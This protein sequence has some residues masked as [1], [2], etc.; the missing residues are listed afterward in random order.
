MIHLEALRRANSETLQFDLSGEK[1]GR[2]SGLFQLCL[3]ARERLEEHGTAIEGLHD[4][5]IA[6]FGVSGH[7]AVLEIANIGDLKKVEAYG[8]FIRVHTGE[9]DGPQTVVDIQIPRH[10]QAVDNAA[11]YKL[12]GFSHETFGLLTKLIQDAHPIDKDHY[13]RFMSSKGR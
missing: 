1:D 12:H 9:K 5:K 6:Y 4:D 10:P 13:Q 7:I 2:V 8:L 11:A 3:A